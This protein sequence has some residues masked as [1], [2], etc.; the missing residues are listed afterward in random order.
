[1]SLTIRYH[2]NPIFLAQKNLIK[3]FMKIKFKIKEE[4]KMNYMPV[5]WTG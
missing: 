1:M 3:K 5:K 4:L 2:F